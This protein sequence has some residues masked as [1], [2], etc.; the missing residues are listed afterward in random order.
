VD[1]RLVAATDADLE[2]RMNDGRFR[3]PLMM[4]LSGYELHIPALRD[5]PDDIARLFV[6]FLREELEPAGRADLLGAVDDHERAWLPCWLVERLIAYDWPGNVREL[7]NFVRQLVIDQIDVP[8]IE[9]SALDWF[10]RRGAAPSHQA[11]PA[12]LARAAP[13][14]ARPG[15]ALEEIGD[16][17]VLEVMRRH[18]FQPGP[19]AGELGISRGSLYALL[20]RHPRLR[21]ARDLGQDEIVAAL[22]RQDGNVIRAAEELGVSAR[23]L[24]MQMRVLGLEP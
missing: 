1:V 18:R 16:D 15:R 4:R 10:S 11:A 20:E 17:E 8:R 23:A 2:A 6:H 13:D 3:L 7:R 22:A 5:R 21:K 24:R 9:R 14:S 19:A 12:P